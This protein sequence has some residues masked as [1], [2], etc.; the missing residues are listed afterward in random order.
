MD[1]EYGV[2]I[3]EILSLSSDSNVTIPEI[4]VHLSATQIS[5]LEQID[6][7][8]SSDNYAI[9]IYE[10]TLDILMH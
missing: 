2:E 10:R 8:I 3:D 6:P 4:I 5:N 1:D 7:L 9:D